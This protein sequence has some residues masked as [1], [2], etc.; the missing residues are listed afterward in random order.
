MHRVTRA[1]P[2]RDER[3]ASAVEF[4]L[5]MPILFMLL[6]GI[7]TSGLS[8]SHAIGVTNAVRE[9]SRFGATT[10]ACGATPPACTGGNAWATSVMQRV[11]D[12]QFDDPSTQT[13]VCVQLV[14][15]TAVGATAPVVGFQCSSGGVSTLT[16][17][18]LPAVPATTTTVGTCFV[19]VVAARPFTINVAIQKW[20]RTLVRTSI[21][22]YERKD[23]LPTCL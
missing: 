14:R 21:A 20:D 2:H 11:R 3:G 8:Y 5:V 12:T 15:V 23:K 6:L 10:D 22:R 4:A 16:A 7:T 17:S 19:Q 13:R 9:G 18:N 1:L